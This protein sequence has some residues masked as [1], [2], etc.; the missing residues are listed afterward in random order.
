MKPV[1]ATNPATAGKFERGGGRG[2]TFMA[3]LTRKNRKKSCVRVRFLSV[4]H[5]ERYQGIPGF[6]CAHCV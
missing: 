2:G 5:I 6:L 4:T 1:K 3:T